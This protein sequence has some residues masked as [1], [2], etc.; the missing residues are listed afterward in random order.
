M[1]W[2]T[3]CFVQHVLVFRLRVLVTLTTV[4]F[5]KHK[6]VLTMSWMTVKIFEVWRSFGN[7]VQDWLVVW[8][9][10][11]MQLSH[12]FLLRV[13]G[14]RSSN[15]Q[16]PP[17][18]TFLQLKRAPCLNVCQF[19]HRLSLHFCLK[20]PMRM[21]L[22][23]CWIVVPVRLSLLSRACERL[24]L[25]SRWMWECP[26]SKLPMVGTLVCVGLPVCRCPCWFQKREN[27][28]CRQFGKRP[29][30]MFWL[31]GFSTTYFQLLFCVSP[32]GIFRKHQTV[33]LWNTKMVRPWW[34][35]RI[36]VDAH[37][38]VCILGRVWTRTGWTTNLLFLV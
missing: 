1:F 22:G 15:L 30:C 2:I 3:V 31:V 4:M 10:L 38:Y 11:K 5:L 25:M 37:G 27:K 26:I 35:F 29:R 23:G 36:F 18:W 34:K 12:W 19:G 20:W 9:V 14:F 24:G 21:L 32:D 16:F 28:G 33:F 13:P 17:F 8:R 6:P 7:F